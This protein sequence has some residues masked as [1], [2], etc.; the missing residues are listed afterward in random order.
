MSDGSRSVDR[1]KRGYG[2]LREYRF[3]NAVLAGK[4][5][6]EA[7]KDA[8][9][10]ATTDNALF[11]V[12]SRL[13]Q[14]PS[15]RA[16]VRDVDAV[17]EQGWAAGSRQVAAM[18]ARLPAPAQ[19]VTMPDGTPVVLPPVAPTNFD[20]VSAW[21]GIGRALGKFTTKIEVT[22]THK[23]A[24]LGFLTAKSVPASEDEILR[25]VGAGVPAPA[26]PATTASADDEGLLAQI[27]A[28][29]AELGRRKSATESSALVQAPS[30]ERIRIGDPAVR[31]PQREAE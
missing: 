3:L 10:K 6:A 26:L 29:T 21:S 15:I 8:G 17:L 9:S 19:V 7:A 22:A 1:P 27:A 2:R 13:M 12:G 14:R 28:L 20:V 30:P 25:G 31:P 18:A 23:V 24:I 11:R 16:K 5:V 4:S